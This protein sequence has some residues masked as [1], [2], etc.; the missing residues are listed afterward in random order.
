MND[1]VVNP[2]D[3][4][5]YW[6]E[7]VIRHGGAPH[8]KNSSLKLHWFQLYLV[9]VISFVILF[10]IIF[11]Y[12]FK[13]LLRNIYRMIQKNVKGKVTATKHVKQKTT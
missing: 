1:Q 8:I 3:L 11:Y 10:I 7:Y 9:D 12:Y 2:V 4:A 5:I 13:L 6:L